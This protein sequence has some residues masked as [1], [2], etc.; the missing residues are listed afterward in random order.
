MRAT[1]P[2]ELDRKWVRATA[3][4]DID[5]LMDLIEE[6]GVLYAPV[7]K[8]FVGHDA[9]RSLCLD[10]MAQDPEPTSEVV[11]VVENG[12]LAL[13]HTDYTLA[14]TNEDGRWETGGRA[15]LV[16]RRHADGSWKF[17]I[18]NRLSGDPVRP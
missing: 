12:D 10:L 15:S 18:I 11:R 8:A 4:K 7:G 1:T 9:I 17:V 14:A 3:D 16:A 6:D 13:I 5:G 2:R